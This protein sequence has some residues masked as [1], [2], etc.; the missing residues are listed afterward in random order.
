MFHSQLKVM[1]TFIPP[2][3]VATYLAFHPQDNNIIS[4]GMEDSTIQIYNVRV[5]EVKMKLKGHQ[6]QIIGLSFSQNLRALVSSGAD[7]HLCIWNTNGYQAYTSI[8]G[9]YHKDIYQPLN[10]IQWANIG[11]FDPRV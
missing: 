11:A 6:K 5:D 1:T 7:A 2:P 10:I 8:S 3:P 4:I 9:N